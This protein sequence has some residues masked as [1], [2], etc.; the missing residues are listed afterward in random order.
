MLGELS[1]GERD[2][3]EAHF[4]ECAICGDEVRSA[5]LFVEN[6]RAVLAEEAVE[7][8]RKQESRLKQLLAGW[9]GWSGMGAWRPAPAFAAVVALVVVL[10]GES[11]LLWQ[12]RARLSDAEAPRL[13][14]SAVLR[15]ETRGEPV[16]IDARRG[17]P[18]LLTFDIES[19]QG[20]PRYLFEIRS[21]SGVKILELSAAAPPAEKP[22][23]LSIPAGKLKAGRH[24]LVVHGVSATGET[25]SQLGQYHFE[26]I[27]QKDPAQ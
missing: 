18:L 8:K 10:S 26:L 20:Y 25:G 5:D 27:E 9:L 12:A 13:V 4:F 19:P 23:T 24:T 11:F 3:F 7:P 17:S 21:I 15:P 14:A 16:R 1:P 22:V 2:D 6:L